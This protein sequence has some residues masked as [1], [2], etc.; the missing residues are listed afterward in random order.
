MTDTV[1]EARIAEERITAR[2]VAKASRASSPTSLASSWTS[3]IARF[4]A[5]D[6]ATLVLVAALVVI[7]LCTFKD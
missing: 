7:A 2:S 1:S 6:F 5:Y 3:G 4:G